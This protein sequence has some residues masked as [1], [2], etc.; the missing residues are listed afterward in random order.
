MYTFILFYT[1][2]CTYYLKIH[3]SHFYIL[4]QYL[5]VEQSLSG[6]HT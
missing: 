3:V 2:I 1:Y 4:I 5:I 6:I